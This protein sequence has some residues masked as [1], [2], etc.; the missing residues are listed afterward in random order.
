MATVRELITI[1][2][3]NVDHA[4][5][6][7]MEGNIK[8]L[9]GELK[10]TFLIAAGGIATMF[11]LAKF[12][13]NAGEAVVKGSQKLQMSTE[14]FQQYMHVIDQADMSNEEF[15]QGF[16]WMA[17]TAS[18][19]SKGM[20]AEASK[21]FRRLGIDPRNAKKDYD[22]FFMEVMGGIGKINDVGERSS[23]TKAIFGRGGQNFVNLAKM[24]R[25][26]MAALKQEAIDLG[27]VMSKDDV[28][29]AQR[30]NDDLKRLTHTATGFRNE[31]GSAL[32]PQMDDMVKHTIKWAVE[33]RVAIKD[34][35][36]GFAGGFNQVAKVAVPVILE[37]G[38]G[39][40][41][42]TKMLGGVKVVT[43]AVMSGFMAFSGMKIVLL[44]IQAAKAV[45]SVTK[46]F[47][48]LK[49]VM[50]I[51]RFLGTGLKFV[52]SELGAFAMLAFL[53]IQDIIVFF[54]GGDSAFGRI[55][56][57]LGYIFSSMAAA[58][59]AIL[60][61]DSSKPGH[62]LMGGVGEKIGG[63]IGKDPHVLPGV[64]MSPGQRAIVNNSR[65]AQVHAPISLVVPPG[66]RPE[67]AGRHIEKG[68]D[69]A[70]SRILRQTQMDLSPQ[71]AH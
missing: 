25:E 66:M 18:D 35:A 34:F 12:T 15:S 20:S 33:H 58:A 4:P 43:V 48:A 60:K 69:N 2:G 10:T 36:T 46:S 5:L 21:A 29:A 45:G 6:K 3:F 7:K 39:A 13:A 53:W 16:L 8:S 55:L 17:R 56:K 38:K 42:L 14:K 71:E 11:G 49:G 41:W 37:M 68:V 22:A 31:I 9:K 26:E 30:F 63:W 52:F 28:E 50:A 61:L 1:W 54:R 65:V 44:F 47:F 51:V 64:G 62:S 59:V 32:I 57:S 27:Y 67:V 24:S 23:I 40:M 19:A 70:L